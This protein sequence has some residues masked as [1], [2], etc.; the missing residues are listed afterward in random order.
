MENVLFYDSSIDSLSVFL[1]IYLT[2]TDDFGDILL[3]KIE[4][5]DFETGTNIAIPTNYFL[6]DIEIN[7]E[8]MLILKYI[9]NYV[10]YI[11]IK[12]NLQRL[13]TI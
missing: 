13:S 1:R 7:T 5:F 2:E 12:T 4:A 8:I 9:L 10:V 6:R 11:L 3:A